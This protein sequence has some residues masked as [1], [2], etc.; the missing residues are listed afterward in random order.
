MGYY[1]EA[2]VAAEDLLRTATTARLAPLAQ[3]LALLP[4]TDDLH[5]ALTVP[6]A[7]RLAP[8][9]MLPRGFDRTLAGWSATGPVAYVEAD[10][11]GGT[12]DQS[13][14]VWNAGA[15]TLG[16][17]TAATGSPVSLAL[18]HLGAT[19]EGHHDEFAAVGLGRH[20][21]TESWLTGD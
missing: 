3:G 19:G 8:F 10:F 12:G 18:R 16:P 1:L 2:V 5:D 9:R 15:L 20:R 13:V 4:M 6:A 11:W 7:E 21:R 17:L 14:A